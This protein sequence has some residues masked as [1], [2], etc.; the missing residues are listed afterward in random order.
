MSGSG[1][2]VDRILVPFEGEGSGVAELTWGQMGLWQSIEHAGRSKTVPYVTDLPAGTAVGD[3]ADMLRFMMSRHQS[4]RTRLRFDAERPPRQNCAASGE[5]PLEI[6]DA[7][8][9]DP[10]E[11]AESVSQRYQM[12]DFQFETEWPVRM[13]AVCSDGVLTHLVLVILHTAIDAYGLTALMADVTTRDPRTGRAAGPVTAV[14]P[15]E[16]ARKQASAAGQRHNTASL[17]YLERVLRTVSPSRFGEPKYGGE[18]TIHQIRFISPATRLAVH[19]VAARNAVGTPPVLLASYAVGLARF[20]GV[21][22]VLAMLLVNNRFRPGFADSVSVLIQIVPFLIDVAGVTLDE[23]VGRAAQSV[24][25]AYKNAY[26]NPYEQDEVLERVERERGEEIDLSCY[27]N[28]RRQ[29]DRDRSGE[30]LTP[31][32]LREAVA[33][34]TVSSVGEIHPPDRKLYFNV[35]DAPDGTEFLISADSRFFSPEDLTAV[36][37]GVEAVVVEAALDGN[38]LTG[39]R[40]E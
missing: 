17:R 30:P 13:A 23:A 31:D 38:A 12:D 9:A 3:V 25:N 15:L 32:Q 33:K 27:Y 2:V 5:V 35:D 6:V 36:A 40:A 39:I 34:S 7:G 37:R 14:Q 4:L 21:N 8:A 11:V 20:T 28:D 22:P 24:L 16:Q 1:T 18:Q 29:T 26:Y 10:A 19:S